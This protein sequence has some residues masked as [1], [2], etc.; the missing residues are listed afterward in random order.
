MYIRGDRNSQNFSE[1]PL[2]CTNLVHYMASICVRVHKL[3]LQLHKSLFWTLHTF[4]MD[5]T[6]KHTTSKWWHFRLPLQYV[7]LNWRNSS[8][9]SLLQIYTSNTRVWQTA[10]KYLHQEKIPSFSAHPRNWWMS[11]L[12]WHKRK[13]QSNYPAA[14]H[15][16]Y[17]NCG[18]V[19]NVSHCSTRVFWS[20][21]VYILSV[22]LPWN[23]E[24]SFIRKDDFPQEFIVFVK[25]LIKN[26]PCKFPMC[27]ILSSGRIAWNTCNL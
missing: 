4:N 22:D 9:S 26:G 18:A 13:V 5:T 19:S 1:Y 6:Y 21:D 20:P 12:L 17:V 2:D 24:C 14:G 25:L 15:T 16:P 7:S 8:F 27:Y 23:V 11:Q 10:F 3:S